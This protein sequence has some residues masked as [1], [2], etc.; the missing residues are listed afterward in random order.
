MYT[1]DHG[2]NVKVGPAVPQFFRNAD[3]TA[4]PITKCVLKSMDKG[5]ECSAASLAADPTLTKDLYSGKAIKIQTESPWEVTA[6][7]VDKGF[8]FEPVCVAC[9]SGEDIASWTGHVKMYSE[10]GS[11]IM[12]KNS[13]IDNVRVSPLEDK[14]AV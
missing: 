8:L 12:V 1:V 10:C 3:A 5:T 7:A 11:T 6:H 14:T 13:D 4:C 2:D 9:Q